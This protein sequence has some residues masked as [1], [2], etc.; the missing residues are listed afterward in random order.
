MELIFIGCI[1]RARKTTKKRPKPTV[2]V[3]LG[4]GILWLNYKIL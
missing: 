3:N 4:R 2:S 1:L